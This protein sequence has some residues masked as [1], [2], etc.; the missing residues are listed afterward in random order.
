RAPALGEAEG[1][2]AHENRRIPTDLYVD[3]ALHADRDVPYGGKIEQFVY[4]RFDL[5]Q[6]V[7]ANLLSG[8]LPAEP[9]GPQW[10]KAAKWLAIFSAVVAMIPLG[11][12]W[13]AAFLP[14]LLVTASSTP[15]LGGLWFGINLSGTSLTLT[16]LPVGYA[17]AAR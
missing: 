16:T 6:R 2:L 9:W 5:R 10:L 7:I 3:Y 17:E 15:A 1:E 13:W 14:V 8:G 11:N 4:R 12:W